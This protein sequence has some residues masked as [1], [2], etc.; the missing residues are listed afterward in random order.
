GV[1]YQ[2]P[3]VGPAKDRA[4][5]GPENNDRNCEQKGRRSP[6]LPLDPTGKPR[7]EGDCLSFG[8]LF[9]VMAQRL[10]PSSFLIQLK[11]G[12][13][14]CS[15]RTAKRKLI[16]TRIREGSDW[17]RSAPLRDRWQ[18]RDNKLLFGFAAPTNAGISLPQN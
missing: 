9:A 6:H 1:D 2:L 17:R 13:V 18:G 16:S 14:E 7:K 8:V 4:R 10:Q 3:G 5:G 12:S 15:S 11:R